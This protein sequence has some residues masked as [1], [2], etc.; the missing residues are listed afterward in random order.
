ML[1]PFAILAMVPFIMVLGNSMLIPVFPLLEEE[2]KLSQF[3]VGL[4]VTAFSLPAGIVIPFAGALSDHVGRKTVM[5]PAL[6]LYGAGGLIAG[7]A[8]LWLSRPFGW[9]LAGRILQGVGAGGTYQIALALT[10]DLFQGPERAKVVGILEAANGLGKMASP[11]AG[12][13]LGLIIWF[14]PFFAYWD[15]RDPHRALGLVSGPGAGETTKPAER[16]G[17]PRLFERHLQKE[18]R[19]APCLL[20]RRGGRSFS[21][22]W[23]PEL[24]LR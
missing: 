6:L 1:L 14:A 19:A 18:G 5:A 4:L 20:P 9:I 21:P 10:G 11:I 17:I 3:Q 2:L 15:P 23:P 13:A 8:S 24:Y 12:A 7:F 16:Q 22:L